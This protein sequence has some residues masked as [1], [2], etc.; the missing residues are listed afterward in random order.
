[1]KIG[2]SFGR[3]IRDIVNGDVDINDVLVII[4]RTHMETAAHV[5]GVVD[6]YMD[7]RAYLDGLDQA[8]CLDVALTLWD[9]GRIHQPRVYGNNPS[10]VSEKY[11]WMDV[12]PSVNDADE[13]V[14]DAW[15]HYRAMLNLMHGAEVPK[16]PASV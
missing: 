16:Q 1:M 6:A 4:A 9:S 14:K 10:M 3:C 8:K 11:L 12:S 15:N 7:R 2:F 5:T 13:I